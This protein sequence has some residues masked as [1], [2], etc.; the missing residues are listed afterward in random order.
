MQEQKKSEIRNQKQRSHPQ[1]FPKIQHANEWFIC[2]FVT[3]TDEMFQP[4]RSI[5]PETKIIVGICYSIVIDRPAFNILSTITT[6]FN[7]LSSSSKDSTSSST[8]LGRLQKILPM[9]I[10]CRRFVI[11]CP[12]KS[13]LKLIIIIVIITMITRE[14]LKLTS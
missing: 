1:P 10:S 12:P 2:R 13:F 8:P 9:G 11:L 14:N 4:S 5:I 6:T 3:K 7:R